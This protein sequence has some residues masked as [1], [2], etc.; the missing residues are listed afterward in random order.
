M[1]AL[2]LEQVESAITKILTTGQAVTLPNGISYSR[3]NLQTL[4]D[5]RTTLRI[6]H[7]STQ[8][9]GIMINVGLDRGCT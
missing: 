8:T 4:M 9:G 6:E 3:A 7:A 1:A 2:T 5:L